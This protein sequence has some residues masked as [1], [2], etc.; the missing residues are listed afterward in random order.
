MITLQQIS[1]TNPEWDLESFVHVANDLLPQFLPVAETGDRAQGE[2][3]PR[4]VRYYTTQ[5]VLDKPF[6]QGRKARYV[7]RHL[8]QL[9]IV[10]RLLAEGYTTGAIQSIT[11]VKND[12][13]LEALLQGG[14]QLT[15]AAA[16]PALAFLQSVQARTTPPPGGLPLA[17][18]QGALPSALSATPAPAQ[19]R[20]ATQSETSFPRWQRVEVL[21][22]LEVHVRED[23]VPPSTPQEHENLLQLMAQTLNPLFSSRR[24]AP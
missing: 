1:Q 14:V 5:G 10:R 2:V 19:R 13:D 17:G 20:R 23:F 11:T 7:Y 16:N 18:A 21:P 15:V 3:N 6:R 8:L 4:L 12:H 9:L 22:G 24:S